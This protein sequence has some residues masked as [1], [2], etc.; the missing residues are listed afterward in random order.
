MGLQKRNAF[1]QPKELALL[2]DALPDKTTWYD[3]DFLR[4][5]R[6]LFFTLA[7]STVPYEDLIR[8]LN[9][10][11]N[12]DV[13]ELFLQ[14]T[15]LDILLYLWNLY[16]LWYEVES[17]KPE[18]QRSS[19][20]NFLHPVIV[21]NLQEVLFKRLHALSDHSEQNEDLVSDDDKEQE[22]SNSKTIMDEIIIL[23]ALIGFLT[24]WSL[25]NLEKEVREKINAALPL[26][27]L[28]KTINAQ[29]SFLIAAFCLLGL[30]WLFGRLEKRITLT[31]ANDVLSKIDNYKLL[32]M[33]A[34]KGLY[35]TFR[36]HYDV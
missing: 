5:A 24:S 16:A 32:T 17:Q 33:K 30:E 12:E 20:R 10:G 11:N 4:G 1:G 21:I 7:D 13:A 18:E 26:D 34:I 2:F 15:T 3:E 19:F 25:I 9:L 23:I 36:T 31:L 28:L 29:E 27:K 6:V 14:G 8:V 35:N 22:F